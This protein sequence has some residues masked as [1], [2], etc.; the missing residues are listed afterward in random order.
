MYMSKSDPNLKLGLTLKV[1]IDSGFS[2]S[3]VFTLYNHRSEDY[4]FT[5]GDKITQ[6]VIMSIA[7]AKLIETDSLDPTESGDGGFGS[8]GR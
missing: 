8:S 3:T 1:V 7:N 4:W 6:L 5:M 2:G